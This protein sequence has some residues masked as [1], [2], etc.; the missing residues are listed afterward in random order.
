[1]LPILQYLAFCQINFMLT[2]DTVESTDTLDLIFA[3]FYLQV[4][5]DWE[6][7]RAK[8]KIKNFTSHSLLILHVISL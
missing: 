4:K 1:M 2:K 8:L 7:I 3:W 6:T 5:I